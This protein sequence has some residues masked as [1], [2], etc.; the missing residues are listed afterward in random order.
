M[1]QDNVNPRCYIDFKQGN[2]RLGRIIIEL[3]AD[4]VPRTAHNFIS[5][6]KGESSVMI[7]NR[8]TR[9]Y[10]KNSIVHRV[11][12]GFMLQMGDFTRGDGTGGISI[13]GK[14]FD[15]ENFK[16]KHNKYYLS[17]ANAG[18]QTNGSQFFICTANCDHLNK[19]HVVFGKVVDG[20]DIVDALES[21]E[22]NSKD[23]PLV[24]IIVSKCGQLMLVKKS[25]MDAPKQEENGQPLSETHEEE[26]DE[27]EEADK[28]DEDSESSEG[29]D[30]DHLDT[31]DK[32][33]KQK[34]TEFHMN[35]V[36]YLDESGRTRKGRGKFKYD[37][38]SHKSHNE[39]DRNRHRN[40]VRTH[41][42]YNPH[43]TINHAHADRTPKDIH[44][45]R[46][47][48]VTTDNDTNC[49]SSMVSTIGVTK[50]LSR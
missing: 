14:H 28:E 32:K 6:C 9:L 48:F 5:L 26:E 36:H 15:D 46:S 33:R 10:Y 31:K 25:E 18:P 17:M 44:I 49:V 21:V 40:R 38:F 11:I 45:I 50:S 39:R 2:E 1:A 13:Y 34:S 24:P 29:E 41:E 8:K 27:E 19:K 30:D 20:T 23:K 16:I 43:H 37:R 22:T 12:K 4:I 7:N 42:H 35:S 3:F 47:P